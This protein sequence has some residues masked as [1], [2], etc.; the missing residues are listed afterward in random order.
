MT[1]FSF[2]FMKADYKIYSSDS[3]LKPDLQF[4]FLKCSFR[5]VFFTHQIIFQ[6]LQLEKSSLIHTVENNIIQA[7]FWEIILKILLFLI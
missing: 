4:S 7:T 2:C 1:F 5:N 3:I 6:N